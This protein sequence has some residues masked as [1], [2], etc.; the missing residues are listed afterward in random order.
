MILNVVFFFF[1]KNHTNSDKNTS[2]TEKY[3]DHIPCSFFYK[4][5]CIDDKFCKPDVLCR[6]KYLIY[7]FIEA[8]LEEYEY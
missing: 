7:K 8:I 1:L 6:G 2:Y 5:I 3:Q 4:L